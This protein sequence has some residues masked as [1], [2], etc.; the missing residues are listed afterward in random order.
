[1]QV[2]AS[3][4][5]ESEKQIRTIFEEPYPMMTSCHYRYQ[6]SGQD[7]ADSNS[8]NEATRGSDKDDGEEAFRRKLEWIEAHATTWQDLGGRNTMSGDHL[9]P[10][11]ILVRQPDPN[12]EQNDTYIVQMFDVKREVSES[13]KL[14]R[15]EHYVKGVPRRAILFLDSSSTSNQQNVRAFRH[16]I[17]IPDDIWPDSWRDLQ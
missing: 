13:D 15:G 5:N 11:S 14:P 1:M 3:E 9:R 6:A 2:S 17:R 12:G 7:A 8:Y 4:L 10:C 16:E